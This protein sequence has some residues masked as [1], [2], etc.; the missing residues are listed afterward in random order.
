M[1]VQEVLKPW[2]NLLRKTRK[3]DALARLTRLRAEPLCL[4]HHAGWRN[5]AGRIAEDRS[6]RH[7]GVRGLLIQD[8]TI[9][10]IL[11]M[12]VG[13]RLHRR[14]SPNGRELR[15]QDRCAMLSDVRFCGLCH[16]RGRTRAWSP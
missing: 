15:R 7:R 13:S 8:A 6:R 10:G 14:L 2:T 3:L 11:R 9:S 5:L 12:H 4:T 16:S 1:L